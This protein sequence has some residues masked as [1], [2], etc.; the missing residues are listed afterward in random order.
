MKEVAKEEPIVPSK[1]TSKRLDAKALKKTI[2]L[3]DRK[4]LS[5][6]LKG[7]S[8]DSFI[9]G[10]VQLFNV[11]VADSYYD[12][13]TYFWLEDMDFLGPKY[14]MRWSLNNNRAYMYEPAL[15][16]LYFSA[17]SKA[18]Y[19]I[20]VHAA[21]Y[22]GGDYTARYGLYLP[23]M[24][25]TPLNMDDRPLMEFD[26]PVPVLVYIDNLNPNRFWFSGHNVLFESI[27]VWKF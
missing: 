2:D 6:A 15:V 17:P 19:L 7:Q 20:G 23:R 11:S 21:R 16:T 27:S 14:T 5:K 1:P 22:Q 9:E 26:P 8:V 4:E 3:V 24:E 13:Q 10:A 25:R 12:E 18:Y